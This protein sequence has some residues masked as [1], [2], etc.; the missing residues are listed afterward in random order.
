MSE[1]QRYNLV[2]N[3]SIEWTKGIVIGNANELNLN[4]QC[5]LYV[6]DKLSRGEVG[7]THFL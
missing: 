6:T 4:L 3:C 2:F 1:L 7:Y 5:T